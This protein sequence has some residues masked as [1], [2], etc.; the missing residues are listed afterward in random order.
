LLEREFLEP[1]FSCGPSWVVVSELTTGSEHARFLS[2]AMLAV[3]GTDAL[4]AAGGEIDG[5]AGSPRVSL[6]L[7][8]A[9]V[10]GEQAEV[11]CFA[12]QFVDKSLELER[13]GFLQ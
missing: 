11:S 13:V 8:T 10:G 3:G 1:L 7:G 9:T 6:G 2:F 5:P 12:P 4:A